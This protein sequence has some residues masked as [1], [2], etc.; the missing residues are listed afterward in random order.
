MYNDVICE[1]STKIWDGVGQEQRYCVIE[2]IWYQFNVDWYKLRVLTVIPI[3][4]PKKIKNILKRNK[5]E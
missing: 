5:E 1:I 2:L 4:T 3:V